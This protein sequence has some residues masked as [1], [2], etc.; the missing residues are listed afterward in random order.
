MQ[1]PIWI[2]LVVAALGVVGTVTAG[3]AGVLITQRR[4]D[5][6]EEEIS[7]RER[8]REREHWAREDTARTFEQRQ[9]AYVNY[10][11][12]IRRMARI[13][14][15]LSDEMSSRSLPEDWGRQALEDANELTI[16]GS[17]AAALMS[18]DVYFAILRW[19]EVGALGKG[20]LKKLRERYYELESTFLRLI[21]EELSVPG[22]D[23]DR[24][25]V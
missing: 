4:A 21:R 15:D 2:P 24:F 25:P 23:S 13:A 20:D 12:S 3:I 11:K 16:F 22:A 17:S 14:D 5:R 9:R 7:E 6:R 8:R 1:T 10:Y 18:S 19:G